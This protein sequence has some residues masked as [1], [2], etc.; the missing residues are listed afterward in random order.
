[1]NKYIKE[2]VPEIGALTSAFLIDNYIGARN[3]VEH[4]VEAAIAFH[5]S[6]KDV[7]GKIKAS[8]LNEI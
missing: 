5:P 8:V 6:Q 7:P 3:G 4:S 2:N 1:M